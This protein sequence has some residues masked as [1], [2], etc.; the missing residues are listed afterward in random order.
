MPSPSLAKPGP[1]HP[2]WQAEE[3]RQQVTEHWLL[4]DT[5]AWNSVSLPILLGE[6]F[7]AG[8]TAGA[9][10]R[11]VRGWAGGVP[12]ERAAAGPAAGRAGCGPGS[13]RLG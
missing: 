9:P 2:E 5:T 10:M 4:R 13:L 1:E 8:W 11:R 6:D 12:T 3:R 7:P